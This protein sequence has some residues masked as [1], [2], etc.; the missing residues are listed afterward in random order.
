M[1]QETTKK[2]FKLSRF[3]TAAALF[4]AANL[5]I[6][7]ASSNFAFASNEDSVVHQA[8]D[9]AV[10]DFHE[11]KSA[12]DLVLLGSSLVAGPMWW[13]DAKRHPGIKDFYHHH[14]PLRLEELL[15]SGGLPVSTFSFAVPGAMVSD[16]Y[17]IVDK[18]L[19]GEAQ[20]KAL[21]YG[22]SPRDMMDD[23]L[24]GETR[25]A[26][27]GRLSDISDLSGNLDL[28]MSSFSEK[29][30]FVLNNVVFVYGKR[31]RYQQKLTSIMDKCLDRVVGKELVAQSKDSTQQDLSHIVTG[32]GTKEERWGKSQKEYK[33]R[34]HHFNQ[35]QFEKQATFLDRL[36][37]TAKQRNI[38]VILV[39]M[40][41][42]TDNMA[43]MPDGFY[44]KYLRTVSGIAG[45]HG[46]VMLDLNQGKRWDDSLFLDTAHL[47][48]E[49]GE[50]LF[51]EL[52]DYL[53]HDSQIAL[54]ERTL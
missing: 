15:K 13:C 38:S 18:V 2:G 10:F 23:L 26:V 9:S 39:N 48:G 32:S 14:F 21:V 37:A 11:K 40:P 34:Y 44:D 19:D 4:I 17:L 1:G 50:R 46:T 47:N 22:I 52:V 45:R 12:P 29:L 7:S 8:I 30:D 31:Y 41:L 27:F 49:G 51:S 28:Y 43:M 54:T 20:P 36:L 33:A 5:V 24:T 42:T 16:S 3:F 53:R 25:T 35:A 6:T